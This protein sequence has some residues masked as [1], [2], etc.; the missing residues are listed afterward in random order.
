[1][2]VPSLAAVQLR[3]LDGATRLSS[4][5]SSPTSHS[6]FRSLTI[7]AAT[8]PIGRRH[9]SARAETTVAIEAATSAKRRIAVPSPRRK[10]PG[11]NAESTPWEDCRRWLLT[12][13]DLL[14]GVQ[15]PVGFDGL[16]CL[17]QLQAAMEAEPSSRVSM[18]LEIESVAANPVQASERRVKFF[19]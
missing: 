5:H 17:H 7:N 9:P 19:A 10:H 4:L 6:D 12:R 13:A 18:P 1:M 16:Q 8:K 15:Q 2:F 14:Q 11:S 3:R